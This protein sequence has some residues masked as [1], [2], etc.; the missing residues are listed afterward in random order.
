MRLELLEKQLYKIF[1]SDEMCFSEILMNY[2]IQLT[3]AH[4]LSNKVL[5]FVYYSRAGKYH[6]IINGNAGYIAQRKVFIHEIKHIIID[7]PKIGYI[8]G[9]DM[10]HTPLEIE[11]DK[12]AESIILYG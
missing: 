6:L 5:G 9:L 10:M 8:I 1:S 11:A 7:M 12:I 2:N 4:D 3:I